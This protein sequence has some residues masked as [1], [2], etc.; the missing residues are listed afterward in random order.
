MKIPKFPALRW[1]LALA[2]FAAVAALA[3]C[4]KGADGAAAKAEAKSVA[5]P[6][7]TVAL[8]T[9]QRVDWPQ[10]LAANGNIVAWQEAV[11]GAEL[12]GLRLTEVLV[13]VG[14]AVKRGQPLARVA[15][16]T[17]TADLA[18]AQASVTEAEAA[19]A[20]AR[21]NAERSRQL[22]SQGFVSPQ[23]TVQLLTAEQ[24]AGA[25][26]AAARARAQ[27]EAVR[28][29][30]TRILAPDDGVIS[31]RTATVGSLTL[32]N[33]ELFR[34][35]RGGRLEWRAEVTGTELTRFE[36]GM[37]ATITTTGGAQIAGTVRSVSPSVDPATRNGIVYVDLPAGSPARA[38]TFARGEFEL[39][40]G[41]ALTLP[42][43]AVV[44]RDGF[45][46]VFLVN[47]ENKVVQ[48]KV[49]VGRR[50]GDRIEI[51]AGLPPSGRVVETGG[52][53]LA[54]GDTVRV[55]DAAAPMKSAQK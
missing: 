17:V 4:G 11:I 44:L 3:G 46:Y 2:A 37:R 27:A 6:A 35:I 7:L 55:V 39:G 13:N 24:T 16:D 32:P 41:S 43:S 20:E 52:G 12:T 21:A 14:D 34:L 38:G 22:Q 25:R 9:P 10:T 26:L 50:V 45:A 53:F 48:N 36:P 42:Q 49:D 19:L 33:Q 18:Q 28:M 51:V 47:A 29:A 5:R 40:R 54:D 15:A 30:Q 31:S 8:V 23:A 1:A